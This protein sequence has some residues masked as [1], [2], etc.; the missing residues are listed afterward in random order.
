MLLWRVIKL[1]KEMKNI[2]Y[3]Q[4]K[5]L[6]GMLIGWIPHHLILEWQ[7]IVHFSH[8]K[9]KLFQTGLRNLQ[10]DKINHLKVMDHWWELHHYVFGH[11]VW[12]IQRIFIKLIKQMLNLCIL[13]KLSIMLYSYTVLQFNI[14]WITPMIL[15]EHKKRM[16]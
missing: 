6:Y 2:F 13:M 14:Y 11:Q 9:R 12:K 8:Y 5:S 4:N 7:Q 16:T 3:Q 1:Q 10:Q 15:I